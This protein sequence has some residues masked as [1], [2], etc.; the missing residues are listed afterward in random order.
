[1]QSEQRHWGHKQFEYVEEFTRHIKNLPEN[2]R[3]NEKKN[4]KKNRIGFH[5]KFSSR[6]LN[7]FI[8]HPNCVFRKLQ[9]MAFEHGTKER[10]NETQNAELYNQWVRFAIRCIYQVAT[11]CVYW[12]NIRKHLKKKTI[13]FSPLL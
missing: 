7:I 10:T 6:Y 1:M 4:K 3:Q 8:Q 2:R 5:L 11:E 13:N 9:A 12:E